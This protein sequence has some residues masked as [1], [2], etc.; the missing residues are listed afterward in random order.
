MRHTVLALASTIALAG[1]SAFVDAEQ[2]RICRTAIPPLNPDGA[3]L[4]IARTTAGSLP[5]RIRIEYNVRSPRLE[6]RRAI[7]CLFAAEGL[8]QQ[9]SVIT[10][11]ATE[12]GP[13]PE[14]SFYFLRRFY[15]N[16]PG[17]PPPDPGA[18][19]LGANVPSLPHEA[20]YGLQQ[21][22][23]ALPAMAI[24]GL[25]AASYALIFGL[26]GRIN[27]AFGAFAAL[28][29]SAA[30]V[31]ILGMLALGISAPIPGL[32]AGLLG[33]V[34][35][36]AL[37]GAVAA[38]LSVSPFRMARGQPALIAS[39]GLYLALSEYLRLAQGATGRWIPPVANAPLPVARAG[40]FVVTI[41]PMALAVTIAGFAAAAAIVATLRF[42][43]FGRAWRACADDPRAAA[44]FGIDEGRLLG[45]TFVMACGAAGIAGFI[46]VAHYGGLG[47][48]A[49][50]N[51]GLKALVAAVLGG[52]GSVPGAFLGGVLIA[53]CEA[54]W[55]AAL[56]IE[57]RDVAIFSLIA[58]LMLFRPTGLLGFEPP[59][60]R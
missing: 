21:A 23:A 3:E 57:G 30:T 60:W 10:G 34:F 48:A 27:L 43:R 38:R 4:R 1:C 22:L 39:V 58:L 8:D 20:A 31:T 11:I 33:A 19:D 50:F 35:A 32:L 29:G 54:L 47:F 14:A 6:G 28:G 44:L 5:G 36:S 46:M 25:L 40:D 53:L 26:V 15:L 45:R 51:L 55:S 59:I 12:R 7:V 49:G 52:I 9:K 42:T 24:Y 13:L 17:E 16:A 2:A 56:P 41:T 18:A 37:H